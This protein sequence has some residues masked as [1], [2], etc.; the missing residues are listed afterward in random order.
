MTTDHNMD[1]LLTLLVNHRHELIIFF[2]QIPHCSDLTSLIALPNLVMESLAFQNCLVEEI[3]TQLAV[4]C[5]CL[6]FREHHRNRKTWNC[7][8]ILGLL[9]E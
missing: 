4:G 6:F 1:V 7:K 2:F 8:T 5:H 9:S 3:E